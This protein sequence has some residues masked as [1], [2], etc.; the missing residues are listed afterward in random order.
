MTKIIIAA[1]CVLA[2]TSAD[3]RPQR[4]VTDATGKIMREIADL[5]REVAELRRADARPLFIAS[6]IAH[7][8]EGTERR[9]VLPVVPI[10]EIAVVVR[11]AI[12]YGEA[13]IADG[14]RLLGR[15]GPSI[16]LPASLWCGDFVCQRMRRLGLSC[17]SNPR[18]A[19]DY[20]SVGTRGSGKRGEVVTLGR[21]G[22]GHVGIVTGRCANG[23]EVLSGNH[24]RRVAV[25]CYPES[26]VVAYRSLGSGPIP[27]AIASLV[28]SGGV[29]SPVA[30]PRK[31]LSS[32][33]YVRRYHRG[34]RYARRSWR[35]AEVSGSGIEFSAAGKVREERGIAS[36]Y[37]SGQR[38]ACGGR[39]DP[40][41]L[42][43]AHRT[44]PCGTRVEVVNRRS[45]ARVVVRIN[46][47]GPFVPGRVIDVSRA[48]AR[49]LGLIGPGLAPVSVRRI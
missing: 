34:H 39:F 3:A 19:F 21:G 11:P 1:A 40:E 13:M 9:L 45:G 27:E 20:A 32:R 44:L 30:R 10:P 24:S 38:V 25:S 12:S 41:A 5:R 28:G 26:R 35:R 6:V 42:T 43:A 47:R 48:A 14:R 22:G 46:D 17:P 16:G 31:G 37:G 18:W 23:P 2:A 8:P 36:Y 49:Q 7:P 33:R 15:S 29:S 4:H